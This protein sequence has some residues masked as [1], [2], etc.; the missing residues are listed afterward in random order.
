MVDMPTKPYLYI[1]CQEYVLRTSTDLIQEN[2]LTLKKAKSKWYHAKI[3]TN[4]DYT[5]DLALFANTQTQEE[6]L[7]YRL[8]ISAGGISLYVNA[9]KT[10]FACFKQKGAITTQSGKTLKSVDQFTYIGSS[11]STTVSDVII[12]LVKA[13]NAID[14]ISIIWKSDLSD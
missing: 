7:L 5:D 14:R 9:N 13:W 12:H 10:K 8:D 3:I 6:S 2:G 1:L 4:E 11:I